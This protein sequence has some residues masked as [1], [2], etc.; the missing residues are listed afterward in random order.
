MNEPKDDD[1]LPEHVEIDAYLRDSRRTLAERL[2]ARFSV[3]DGLAAIL[4]GE[5]L[6]IM[7][8]SLRIRAGDLTRVID[9]AL[10]LVRDL[11]RVVDR[12][13]PIDR[14]LPGNIVDVLD[15][16]R[17]LASGLSS[18][19][20]S[21]REGALGR[22]LNAALDFGKTA[23]LAIAQAND[24]AGILDR[25]HKRAL[26][27]HRGRGA[28]TDFNLDRGNALDVV[29][30]LTYMLGRGSDYTHSM[31][32]DTAHNVTREHASDCVGELARTLSH[33]QVDA[34]GVDLTGIGLRDL[35][36]L[37]HVTWTSQTVWPPCIAGEVK[38][39]SVEIK[40]G[41][42]EVRLGTARNPFWARV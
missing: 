10:G 42:Y 35:D 29:R 39:N 38:A 2:A 8:I 24:L 34:S 9:L 16:G 28:V 18:D 4:G 32:S 14:D 13:A 41:V 31:I 23:D 20:A 19:L 26:G 1:L 37:N 36:V 7:L 30:E 11:G 33:V 5:P 17:D 6:A 15:R 12:V 40:A 27:L 25:G 21:G 3:E 22:A